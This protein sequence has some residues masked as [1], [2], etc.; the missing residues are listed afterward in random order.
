MSKSGDKWHTQSKQPHLRQQMTETTSAGLSLG[1]QPGTFNNT[2]KFQ[3]A[4]HHNYDGSGNVVESTFQDD[5]GEEEV[6]FETDT[7]NYN[8]ERSGTKKRVRTA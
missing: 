4:S 6:I 8:T 7:R 3:E 2:A 5:M 1:D